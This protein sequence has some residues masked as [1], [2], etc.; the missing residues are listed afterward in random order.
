MQAYGVTKLA[1]LAQKT[2][3]KL[4]TVK[5]WKVRGSVPIEHCV[6]AAQATGR[7]L[8]WIVMGAL[9]TRY[10]PAGGASAPAGMAPHVGERPIAE[11]SDSRRE[12]LALDELRR[13][14]AKLMTLIRELG[15]EPPIVWTT[16]LQE[17]LFTQ[18]LSDGGARRVLE[19]LKAERGE[20]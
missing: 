12:Q 15:F 9:G 10:E 13:S 5:N 16:M 3:E 17:L 4:S 6:R 11:Y 7:S 19:T 18:Q 2:G 20:K 1:D 14:T 8:D